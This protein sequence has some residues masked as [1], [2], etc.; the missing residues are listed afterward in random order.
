MAAPHRR[1]PEP[2]DSRASRAQARTER[3]SLAQLRPGQSG[4]VESVA[5]D[6]AVTQRLRDLGF[7]A[8]TRIAVLRAAPLGDPVLYELRGYELSLRRSEASRVRIRSVDGSG[9]GA[10]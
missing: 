1:L 7:V 6:D 2:S 5:P 3:V 9:I 10:P 4:V 8:G